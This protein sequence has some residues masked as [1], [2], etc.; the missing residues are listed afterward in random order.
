MFRH[1][2]IEM[3]RPFDPVAA[4][5]AYHDAL[6]RRD[7]KYIGITLAENAVY[8]SKGLGPVEGRDA[9]LAAMQGYFAKHPNHKSWD[10]STKLEG[11][12]VASCTWELRATDNDT[13]NAISRHG[14]ERVTFDAKG[15]I[16][17]V[18]VEDLI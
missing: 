7:F 18:D 17:R 9:I 1:L 6:E 2:D 12:L 4:M 10:T 15:R 3:E 16:I 13:G 14:H 11:R 5:V 8:Q